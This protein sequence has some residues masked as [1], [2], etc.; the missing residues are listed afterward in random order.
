VKITT[1]K[2]ESNSEIKPRWRFEAERAAM[3]LNLHHAV[4]TELHPCEAHLNGVL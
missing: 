3:D 1:E 2:I 4:E